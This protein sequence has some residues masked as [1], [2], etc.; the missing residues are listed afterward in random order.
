MLQVLSIWPINQKPIP[1]VDFDYQKSMLSAIQLWFRMQRGILRRGCV[2]GK[3]LSSACG[4]Y[5][6]NLSVNPWQP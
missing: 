2:P 6:E 5:P 3:K 1:G 4:G